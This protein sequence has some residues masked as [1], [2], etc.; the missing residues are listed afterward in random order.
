MADK[1]VKEVGILI[2][3]AKPEAA[4]HKVQAC[5]QRHIHVCAGTSCAALRSEEIAANLKKEIAQRGMQLQVTIQEGRALITD[6]ANVVEIEP[7]LL[8]PA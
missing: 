5:F 6:G 1:Q 2:T 4:E 8:Q 7:Q 3:S